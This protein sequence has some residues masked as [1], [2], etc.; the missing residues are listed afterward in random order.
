ME[1]HAN[2]QEWERGSQAIAELQG[3]GVDHALKSYGESID[4]VVKEES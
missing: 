1:Y 3:L 4:S 2:C